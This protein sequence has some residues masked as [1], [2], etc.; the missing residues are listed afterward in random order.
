MSA[1]D[2][3]A[4]QINNIPPKQKM[5]LLGLL[6]FI[7]VGGFVWYVY[8]PAREEITQLEGEISTLNAQIA[9]DRAKVRRLDDLK[10]ENVRLQ[11]RLK[12]VTEQI[13]TED[14]ITGL[15]RQVSNDGTTAGL[16]FKVWRPGGRKP[17]PNGLYT[18]IPVS[19]DVRGGFHNV[20][21]FFDT[22]SKMKRIVTISDIT[23]SDPKVENTVN[24]VQVSFKATTYTATSES[25]QQQAEQD[26]MDKKKG[27]SESKK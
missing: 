4:A 3:L 9:T 10:A 21:F 17:N 26:T 16:D 5:L 19:V 11:A 25:E 1:L 27:K 8:L 6:A 24:K 13:P 23:I 20:A 12:E 22:I 7:V 14:E 15:L 2:N 18:E